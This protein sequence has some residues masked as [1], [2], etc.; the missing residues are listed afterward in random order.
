MNN[1]ENNSKTCLSIEDVCKISEMSDIE[2]N[3][4]KKLVKNKNIVYL[5]GVEVGHLSKEMLPK[6]LYKIKKAFNKLGLKVLLYPTRGGAPILTI[7]Q[8]K[9]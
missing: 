2:I 7:H 5:V 6:H 1:N 3:S 4:I 8:L 9:K